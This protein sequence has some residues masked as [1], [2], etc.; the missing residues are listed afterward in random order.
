MPGIAKQPASR[1]I[2]AQTLNWTGKR[3]PSG[4]SRPKSDG[5]DTSAFPLI[6]T[7]KRTSQEV[8]SGPTA[9]VALSNWAGCRRVVCRTVSAASPGGP[10]NNYDCQRRSGLNAPVPP[11]ACLQY[12]MEPQQPRGCCQNAR[13]KIV[14]DAFA[15]WTT[16]FQSTGLPNKVRVQ[17]QASLLRSLMQCLPTEQLYRV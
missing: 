7:R 1:A 8:G 11:W 3:S 4:H 10:A 2:N 16:I 15:L 9:D 5:R 6:A 17:Q 12:Q 14:I 13:L